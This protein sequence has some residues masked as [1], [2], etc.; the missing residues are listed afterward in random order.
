MFSLMIPK[1]ELE[2]IGEEGFSGSL[3]QSLGKAGHGLGM[4]R[5]ARLLKVN[6]GD[7]QIHPNIAPER[8]TIYNDIPYEEN[9]VIIVLKDARGRAR[10]NPLA[11]H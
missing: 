3:P 8:A 4:F 9:Q 7:I 5:A 1:E 2:H 10:A 11:V 6:G